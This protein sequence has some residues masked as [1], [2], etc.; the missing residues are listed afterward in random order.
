MI[1]DADGIFPRGACVRLRARSPPS[2]CSRCRTPPACRDLCV[3]IEP[4][5]R[6]NGSRTR[7]SITSA[8]APAELRMQLRDAGAGRPGRR[9]VPQR[10]QARPRRDRSTAPTL[11]INGAECEPCITCDDMLMRERA[12]EIVQGVGDHAPHAG[13]HAK[14]WSASRTTSPKPSPRCR[15]PRERWTSRWKW[16]RCRRIYPGG[17]AKQ[18]IRVLTGMEVPSGKLLHRHRRAVLQ[19]RH[20]LRAGSA[21]C[22]RRAADLAHGHRHRQC[23]RTAEFRGADRHADARTDHAGRRPRR[24]PP[25]SSWAAR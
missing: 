12:D 10:S 14:C 1:G 7:R 3:T 15:P 13:Q 23:A 17:G 18:L 22:T 11:I 21:R 8:M 25:A 2:T 19:R 20:R 16:W 6:T 5:G 9:G 24:T 4:D